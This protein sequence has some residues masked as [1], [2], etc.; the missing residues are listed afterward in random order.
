MVQNI[1]WTSMRAAGAPLSR[2]VIACKPIAPRMN[3]SGVA[4]PTCVG[5]SSA[6]KTGRKSS[7]RARPSCLMK[8]T[9]W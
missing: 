7:M 6:M 4:K 1:V 2:Q 9:H 5:T 3:T 8:D